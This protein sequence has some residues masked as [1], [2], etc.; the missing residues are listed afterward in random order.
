MNVAPKNVIISNFE[1]NQPAMTAE[2]VYRGELR[3]EL[4]HVLSGTKIFTD[5]PP[6][7]KGKGEAFSPTDLVAVATGACAL[8]TM[9]IAAQTHG[10]NIDGSKVEVTK[11]MA[12]NPRRISEVHIVID[13]PKNNYSE[14][15]KEIIERSALTCPVMLSLHP[16]INKQMKFNYGQ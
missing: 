12:S 8:T 11:V 9:G 3:N 16:D 15:E 5:A 7:N 1:E 4:T 14:K 10:F 6:D 13:L 2:I